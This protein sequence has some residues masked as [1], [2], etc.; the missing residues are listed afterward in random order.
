MIY[1]INADNDYFLA[2]TASSKK[3]YNET[4]REPEI[5]FPNVP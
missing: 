2:V 4:K 1:E 5:T 3:V